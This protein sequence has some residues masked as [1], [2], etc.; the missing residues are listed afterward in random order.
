ML[1]YLDV[2]AEQEVTLGGRPLRAVPITDRVTLEGAVTT[3]YVDRKGNWLGSQNR[4]IDAQNKPSVI[5]ILPTDEATLLALWKDANLT[6]PADNLDDGPTRA[7]AADNA[8][9]ARETSPG[10]SPGASPGNGGAPRGGTLPRRLGSSGAGGTEPAGP[11][12]R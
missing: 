6:R 2:G 9:D 5:T 8:R 7:A 11:G 4:V 10:A 12:K 3:H 1:R